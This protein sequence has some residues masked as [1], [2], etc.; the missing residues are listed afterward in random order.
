LL[1]A[2]QALDQPFVQG[3]GVGEVLRHF[4]TGNA[5]GFTHAHALVRG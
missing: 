1:N 2:L 4:Q 5:K 3:T